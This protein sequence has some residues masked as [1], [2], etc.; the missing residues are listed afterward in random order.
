MRPYCMCT[1]VAPAGRMD[2][3]K[4]RS[5]RQSATL[6]FV[7]VATATVAAISAAAHGMITPESMNLALLFT[8]VIGGGAGWGIGR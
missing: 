2:H 5:R 6:L 3:E 7:S 4:E 8:A 1:P